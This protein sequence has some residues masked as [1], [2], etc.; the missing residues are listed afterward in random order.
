MARPYQ[1]PTRP[2]NEHGFVQK[3]QCPGQSSAL[4]RSIQAQLEWPRE[5]TRLAAP[6]STPLASATLGA[7]NCA[8]FAHLS[9]L[10]TLLLAA[11]SA[12]GANDASLPRLLCPEGFASTVAIADGQGQVALEALTGT[13]ASAVVASHRPA[14]ASPA[15]VK[16]LRDRIRS[17]LAPEWPAIREQL[18]QL[19]RADIG[20]LSE[21]GLATLDPGDLRAL[22]TYFR[23]ESGQHYRTFM[24]RLDALS[25]WRFGCALTL[26]PAAQEPATE[27]RTGDAP[28]DPALLGMLMLSDL[29]Q[30]K[31]AEARLRKDP[32]GGAGMDFV[33]AMFLRFLHRPL[34]ALYREYQ[35]DLAGFQEFQ[36]TASAQNLFAAMAAGLEPHTVLPWTRVHKEVLAQHGAQWRRLLEHSPH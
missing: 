6:G 10:L 9:A 7:M 13:L 14:R 25:G 15:A 20:H 16:D 35:P 18:R 1:S 4:L 30:V 24:A 26:P 32:S 21:L 34:E 5:Q 23:S 36:S 8:R 28:A 11:G 17:D 31:V 22:D 33:F 19:D 12:L 3:T 29:A 27:D 2:G